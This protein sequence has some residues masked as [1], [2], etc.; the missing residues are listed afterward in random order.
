MKLSILII[1]ISL[2][3]SQVSCTNKTVESQT[4]I[5]TISVV[6]DDPKE[7][8]I[9]DVEITITPGNIAKKTDANG[10]CNFELD[11]GDYYVDADVCC[12]GP[13]ASSPFL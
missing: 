13:N 11:P 5:I 6:D 2:L 8:P 1:L 10:L 4:G 7:T 3:F 9:P 12:I